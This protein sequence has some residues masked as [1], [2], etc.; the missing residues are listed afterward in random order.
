MNLGYVCFVLGLNVAYIYCF[1]STIHVCMY[2]NGIR[3]HQVSAPTTEKFFYFYFLQ[4]IDT[5]HI[6][7]L[8]EYKY[9]SYKIYV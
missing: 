6:L 1:S 4:N 7:L 3:D 2:S 5:C 9:L 8:A